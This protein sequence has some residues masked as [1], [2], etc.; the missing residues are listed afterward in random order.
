MSAGR[1]PNGTAKRGAVMSDPTI[2]DGWT[3]PTTANEYSREAAESMIG[4][5]GT[6]RHAIA[7]SVA[8]F[9]PITER[10]LEERHY[11]SGNTVRPRLKELM[12]AGIITLDPEPGVTP[13]GRRCGRYVVT[14]LGRKLLAL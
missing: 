7:C 1:T 11:L 12:N 14:P 4:S 13:S 2:W 6:I 5:A 9:G 10:W 3:L 8:D